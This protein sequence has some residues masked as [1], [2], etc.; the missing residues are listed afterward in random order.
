MLQHHAFAINDLS[1][2]NA[3]T[4]QYAPPETIMFS[5]GLQATPQPSNHLCDINNHLDSSLAILSRLRKTENFR[6]FRN[7]NCRGHKLGLGTLVNSSSR[8]AK[9]NCAMNFFP[10]ATTQKDIFLQCCIASHI[11]NKTSAAVTI[12]K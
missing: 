5:N 9:M 4:P 1:W 3:F 2:I 10:V 8:A 6:I 7:Q 12:F 11:T